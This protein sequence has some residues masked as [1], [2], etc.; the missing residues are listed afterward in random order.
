MVTLEF[1]HS[2]NGKLDYGIDWTFFLATGE[3]ITTSVWTVDTGLVKSLEQNVNNVASLFVTGGVAGTVYKLV[4]SIT[5]S[6]GRQDSRT[7]KLS[8]KN[9]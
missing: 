9:L 5:T 6:A 3:T 2:V 4:N 1:D 7:I 8:C